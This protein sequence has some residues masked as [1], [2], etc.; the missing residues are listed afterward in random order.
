MSDNSTL[1]FDDSTPAAPA[2][3]FNV[4]WSADAPTADPRRVSAA[5]VGDGDATKFFCADGTLKVPPGGGGGG[6]G[7]NLVA[8]PAG[9]SN[10]N[11]ADWTFWVR[12]PASGLLVAAGNKIK[13]GILV[14]SGPALIAGGVI[15]RAAAFDT[16]AFVDSTPILWSGSPSV[17]LA[18][19]LTLSDDITVTVDLN[20]DYYIMVHTDPA[21]TG[22]FVQDT[23]GFGMGVYPFEA[24]RGSGD[25]TAT[26][27]ASLSI[28]ADYLIAIQQVLG[29]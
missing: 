26:A 16:S 3:G 2:N 18:T 24:H 9:P 10:T 28:N 19:G 11:L 5:L 22:S 8:L 4:K 7:G 17:S 15:R 20:H 21:N 14:T 6:S 23:S 29:S 27:L 25:Q 12:I 13:V 1:R